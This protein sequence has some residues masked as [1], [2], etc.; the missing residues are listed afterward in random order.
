LVNNQPL[1]L[2]HFCY[3]IVTNELNVFITD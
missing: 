1:D 2:I 3:F